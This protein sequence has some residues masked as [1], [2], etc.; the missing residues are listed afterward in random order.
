M[1]RVAS[2]IVRSVS[3]QPGKHRSCAFS[4]ISNGKL[5]YMQNTCVPEVH[6]SYVCFLLNI[7]VKTDKADM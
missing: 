7:T 4:V 2:G 6:I 1:D 3:N 5:I